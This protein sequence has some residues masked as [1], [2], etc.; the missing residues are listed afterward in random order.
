MVVLLFTAFLE[1]KGS[2]GILEGLLMDISSIFFFSIVE[3]K[4]R[5]STLVLPSKQRFHKLRFLPKLG[6]QKPCWD[7]ARLSSL[8]NKEVA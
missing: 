2:I 6:C 3:A 1:E 8:V 4:K 7:Q 5:K